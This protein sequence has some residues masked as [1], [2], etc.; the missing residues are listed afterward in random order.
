V[1]GLI[2]TLTFGSRNRYNTL[3]QTRS[4]LIMAHVIK[5]I[6]DFWRANWRFFI[7]AKI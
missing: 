6:I 5:R 7:S 4:H 1:G 2:H 3:A